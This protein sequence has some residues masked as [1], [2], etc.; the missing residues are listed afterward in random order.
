MPESNAGREVLYDE[1]QDAP[2]PLTLV[3]LGAGA[4][5]GLALTR[6]LSLIARFGAAAMLIGGVSVVL[7]EFL[8]PF[9]IRLYSDE[10]LLEYGKRTRYRIRTRHILR[11]Y[12]RRYDPLRE[13]GGWGIRGKDG[14]RAFTFRGKEGVQ[15]ELRSGKKVLIGSQQAEGLAASIRALTGCAGPPGQ[16]LVTIRESPPSEGCDRADPTDPV[17]PTDEFEDDADWAGT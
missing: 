5:G 1:V 14:N 2:W 7:R 3:G 12:E 13:F 8:I 17:D 15:L 4:A 16:P 10:L 11:A 6:A 9:R